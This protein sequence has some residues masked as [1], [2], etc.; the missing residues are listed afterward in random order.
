MV[1]CRMASRS[2]DSFSRLSER[3]GGRA[4]GRVGGR[5]CLHAGLCASVRVCACASVMYVC[6]VVLGGCL[7]LFVCFIEFVHLFS[8][9]VSFLDQVWAPY[10][11][12]N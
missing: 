7:D 8:W 4:S 2:P 3:V 1:R 12:G 11:G 6:V 9:H 10:L 5:A